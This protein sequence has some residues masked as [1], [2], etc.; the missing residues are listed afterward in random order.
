MIHRR[1]REAINYRRD[2]E[3]GAGRLTAS[4]TLE[5]RDCREELVMK[6]LGALPLAI[7]FGAFAWAQAAD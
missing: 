4:A 3:F 6:C 5:F 1:C 7:A 2:S